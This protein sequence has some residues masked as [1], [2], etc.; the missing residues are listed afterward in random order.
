MRQKPSVRAAD[1]LRIAAEAHRS[2]ITVVRVLNGGGNRLSREAV[3][4]AA[5][6]LGIALPGELASAAPELSTSPP[7]DRVRFLAERSKG[8]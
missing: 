1:V 4:D 2:P 8:S 5:R 7:G 3:D 6:S